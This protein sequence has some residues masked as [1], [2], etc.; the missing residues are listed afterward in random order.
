MLSRIHDQKKDT[1]GDLSQ[2]VVF[3]LDGQEF[4]VEIKQAREI[5]NFAELTAIPNAPDFVRGVTN[6]R[7][8]IVPIIDLGE[9]LNLPNIKHEEENKVI[10]VEINNTLI[11]MEVEDVEG[12]IRLA[13]ENIGEAPKITQGINKE[14]ISGVGKLEENLLILLNLNRTLSRDEVEQL[15]D[16]ELD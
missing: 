4:G 7:G 3:K 13:S 5:I 8:E 1:S 14:Y 6:L 9:R 15:E 11:G 10:I 2:Y 16:I 12:I